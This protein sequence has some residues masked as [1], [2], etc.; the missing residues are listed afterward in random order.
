MSTTGER[1]RELRQMN[2]L[3]LDDVAKCL[4]VGRQAV[5]KYETGAVTNIPLENI[6]RMADLFGTT[7]CYIAGWAERDER[8]FQERLKLVLDDPSEQELIKNYR[9]LTLHGKN[10]LLD[11]AKELKIL[12]GKKFEGSAAKSV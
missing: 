2:H 5:Y 11:R 9:S 12:Y 7:P 4:G 6:E 1:I 8:E 3:T 10:L